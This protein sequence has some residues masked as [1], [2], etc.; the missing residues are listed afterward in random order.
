MDFDP[1]FKK[2]LDDFSKKSEFALFSLFCTLKS[3][4]E[5]INKKRILDE[6]RART[7]RKAKESAQA[8]IERAEEREYKAADKEHKA[9]Q[10]EAEINDGINY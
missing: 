4:E 8:E 2:Q 1:V 6:S 9:R 7:E 5:Y 3:A 10:A